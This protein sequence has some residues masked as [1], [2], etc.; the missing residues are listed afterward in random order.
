LTHATEVRALAGAAG[1]DL[2]PTSSVIQVPGAFD[3]TQPIDVGIIDGVFGIS[4]AL[5][6]PQGVSG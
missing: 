2:A 5:P 1:A 4:V 3:I 6:P